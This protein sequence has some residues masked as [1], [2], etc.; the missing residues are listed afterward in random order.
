MSV[1]RVCS[2]SPRLLLGAGKRGKRERERGVEGEGEGEGERRREGEREGW[3]LSLSLSMYIYV[4]SI[5]RERRLIK[6]FKEF[7]LY[8]V[9]T[10]GKCTKLNFTWER[11][12]GKIGKISLKISWNL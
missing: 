2:L 7:S 10:W 1:S 9:I 5:E 4:Y 11:W 8:H 3:S 6:E 12:Q